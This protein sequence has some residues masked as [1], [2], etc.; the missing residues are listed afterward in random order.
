MSAILTT[1]SPYQG[2]LEYPH[3]NNAFLFKPKYHHVQRESNGI[4]LLIRSTTCIRGAASG[5][6]CSVVSCVFKLAVWVTYPLSILPLGWR[7]GEMRSSH[8]LLCQLPL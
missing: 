8:H 4:N 6:A 2:T 1:S 3:E 7:S 5:K